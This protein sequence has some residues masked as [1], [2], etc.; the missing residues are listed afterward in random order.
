MARQ[1]NLNLV[2]RFGN[3]LFYQRLGSFYMKSIGTNINQS[4]ATKKCSG[5]FGNANVFAGIVRQ[6][7]SPILADKN[8]MD[9]RNLL[10]VDVYKWLLTNPLKNTSPQ[11]EVPFITGYEFNSSSAFIQRFK[12]S[13]VVERATEGNLL[14]TIPSLNPM[15][16]IVA[17]AY[18]KSVEL[19]IAAGSCNAKTMTAITNYTTSVSFPYGDAII[20]HKQSCYLL[21]PTPI[22]LP[23]REHHC[24]T[25]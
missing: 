7:L 16:D 13:V 2:G 22:I 18:T 17:P 1:T 3:I 19:C 15:K 14:L 5:D 9:K 24:F 11:N 23:L 12:K 21:P 8:I 6:L 25:P 4:K 10:H 20:L